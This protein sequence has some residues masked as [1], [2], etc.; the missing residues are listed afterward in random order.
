MKHI[1]IRFGDNIETQTTEEKSFGG[2]FQSV[3]P[4]F[5]FSKR[6]WK[7]Q[8]DILETRSEI[9]IQVEIAGVKRENIVI[10]VSNKAVK[11]SGSRKSNHPDQTATYRLAEIQ[12][13][14]FER[15]LYLPSIID[16]EKVSAIF[17]NG[18]LELTLGKF[19]NKEI[20]GKQNVS[21]DFI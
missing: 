21:I 20:K 10:E 4:M 19:L 17:S 6:I 11:I 8:M 18:F 7:P 15:V 2:L 5:C 3:N 13:G 16:V 9:I 1:E 14:Q 12:F